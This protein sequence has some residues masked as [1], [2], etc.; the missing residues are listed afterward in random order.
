MKPN[1]IFY[2]SDQQRADTLNPEVMPNVWELGEEGV[3]FSDLYTCQP[4]CGPA[5]ACLQTGQYAT[6]NKCYWNGIALPEDTRTPAHIFEEN[7]YDTAYIGKWHLASDRYKGIGVHCEKTAIPERRQGG[8]S[9]LRAA[10]VLEFTSHGYDGYVF[11][12]KGN[13]IDFTGYRAD[14]INDFAVEYINNHNGKKPFFMFVSQLEPHHQNDRNRFEGPKDTIENFRD[15]PIPEDLSFLKG[16]YK[17]E[18]PDYIAAVNSLDKNVGKLVET[19]KN[20]GIYDNTIIV[21]TSDHGCHFKTR[22]GEYKRSCHDSSI[23]IPL[24]FG[25]GAVKKDETQTCLASLI[26]LPP[27]LLALAG[28]P[29]PDSYSGQVLPVN[30]LTAPE[31][32][33]VFVQISESQIGR[34]VRTKK[35]KYSA[36]ARGSGNFRHSAKTY[37]DDFLYD[38]ENDPIEKFNL[39][40]DE[41]YEDVINEMRALLSREMVNAGES[42][43]IFRKP[44][45]VNEY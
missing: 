42:K 6:E 28:I 16:N 40:N 11:D 18:Y 25:G 34:A 38:L 15:Y 30:G 4:V 14:C 32:D 21:Y 26:D 35:W 24:V 8:Y 19:L 29:V 31:R 12:E 41:K 33:C 36:R 20:K 43:P 44:K 22:N 10:D 45:K 3:A 39:V 2:F 17:E 5:R 9:Y 37:Y 23:H 7:G 1:I 27:T 13:K